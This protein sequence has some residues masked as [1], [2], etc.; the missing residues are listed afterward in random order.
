MRSPLLG[1]RTFACSRWVV[2]NGNL[3]HEIDTWA[4]DFLWGYAAEPSL[5]LVGGVRRAAI[6]ACARAIQV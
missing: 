4:V 2:S 3:L 6:Q 5:V 1:S